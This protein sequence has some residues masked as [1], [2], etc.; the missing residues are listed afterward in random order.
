MLYALTTAITLGFYIPYRYFGF[1]YGILGR[2]MPI[3]LSDSVREAIL[4]TFDCYSPKYQFTYADY[5][6]FQWFKENG[7]CN[8]EVRPQPVTV[9][10][11]K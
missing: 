9:L 6:V 2:F 3:S 10:G 1:R 4:D 5:E 11:Y 8:I 7:L